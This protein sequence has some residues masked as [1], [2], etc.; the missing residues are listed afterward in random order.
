MAQDGPATSVD[1]CFVLF[2][3]SLSHLM[4]CGTLPVNCEQEHGG[5]NLTRRSQAEPLG[6]WTNAADP[7]RL[8]K[9]PSPRPM[10]DESFRPQR[11]SSK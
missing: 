11:F 5:S 3:S 7:F 9:T 1:H 8:N 2:G 6:P 10:Y 4:F